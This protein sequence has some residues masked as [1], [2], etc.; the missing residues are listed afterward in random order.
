MLLPMGADHTAG[1]AVTSNI[2]NVGGHVGPLAKE[3]NIELSKNLQIA[4][5]GIDSGL[6]CL[7]CF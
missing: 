6:M 3:G 2:L 4:T 7:C 1:Y 5:A